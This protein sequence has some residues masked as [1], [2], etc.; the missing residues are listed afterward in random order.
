MESPLLGSHG[1]EDKWRCRRAIFV[2]LGLLATV[3]SFS[4]LSHPFTLSCYIISFNLRVSFD[5]RIKDSSSR[6]NCSKKLT[7]PAFC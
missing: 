4:Y 3:G 2:P 1:S 7:I 6:Y 5:S